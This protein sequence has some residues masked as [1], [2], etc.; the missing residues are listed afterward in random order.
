MLEAGQPGRQSQESPPHMRIVNSVLGDA[1]GGRWQVVCDY[2]RIL[3]AN[4][5]EVLLVLNRQHLPGL[6]GLPSDVRVE[7]VRNHGHYDYLAAFRVRPHL[8]KFSPA[9]AI[10]HCSRS[11]ALLKRA[12]D[13][14]TP[15]LAVSHSNK[16][17][18][19]LPADA[20]IALTEH[21][22]TQFETAASGKR[23]YRL[24]NMIQMGAVKEPGLHPRHVPVRIGAMG[25]FD[26]VKGF[27]V[28][29]D[30]LALLR[31]Q[32]YLFEATIAG[33]G[34]Q[35][36]TL[37]A[38]LSGAGLSDCV[39]L[40]GWVDD[41]PGFFSRL[42]ILCIPAR[43][44]AF[45]LTP[46]E[47]ARAALPMVLSTASGHGEMFADNCQALFAD[48][49]DVSATAARIARLIDDPQ[50]AGS[51]AEAA[52]RRVADCYSETVISEKLLQIIENY[53]K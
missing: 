53:N 16:V 39:A 47:G 32:G 18:R 44:D 28:L 38:Q 22:A 8:R 1:R 33:S 27:D 30:A 45:G 25:R 49:D 35:R 17:R 11:V 43:S 36:A 26:R 34:D 51:L 15:V 29:I 2:S 24:S 13:P 5:H 7:A 41:V 10:A 4:G 9:L 20:Y 46:L 21:I 14:K 19:L 12:L 3:V 50:L 52:F 40:S 6:D 37:E 23:C 48:V 42:D 31:Q